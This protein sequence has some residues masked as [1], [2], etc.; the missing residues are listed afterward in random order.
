MN[1]IKDDIRAIR[2]DGEDLKLYLAR[3]TA[4][5]MDIQR[6]TS[7]IGDLRAEFTSEAD[8]N[9]KVEKRQRKNEIMEWISNHDYSEEQHQNISQFVEGTGVRG[10]LS[11]PKYLEWEK[12]TCDSLLCVGMPGAGKTVTSAMVIR[13]LNDSSR[14]PDV[15]V[16]V[17]FLYLR[18]DQQHTQSSADQLLCSLTRQLVNQA[19]TIPENIDKAFRNELEPGWSRADL[20]LDAV[21]SFDHVYFVVDALDESAEFK[22]VKDLFS[23]IRPDN[24]R[25]LLKPS[26]RTRVQL[27]VTSRYNLRILDELFKK[28]PP[29]QVEIKGSD[30]DIQHYATSRLSDLPSCV[31]QSA[32]LQQEIVQAIIASTKGVFLHAKLNMDSLKYMRRVK[33][34]KTA[35]K[36]FTSG[37][38]SSYDTSYDEAMSRITA[39]SEDDYRLAQTVLT[40]LVHTIRPLSEVELEA[41]LAVEPGERTLDP[42]NVIPITELQSLCAGL[43][44]V[45]EQARTVRLVHYTTKEYFLRN[46]QKLLVN[47][48]RALADICVSFLEFEEFNSWDSANYQQN[49]LRLTSRIKHYK[50]LT[51]AIVHYEDH[52]SATLPSDD[53]KGLELD[54]RLLRDQKRMD[55]FLAPRMRTHGEGRRMKLLYERK[56]GIQYAAGNGS[57]AQVSALLGDGI[58]KNDTSFGTTP[59]IEACASLNEPVVRLLIDAGADVNLRSTNRNGVPPLMVALGLHKPK[60]YETGATE[61]SEVSRAY[62]YKVNNPLGPSKKHARES[63]VAHLLAAGVDPNYTAEFDSQRTETALMFTARS[64]MQDLVAT[65]CRGGADVNRRDSMTGKTALHVAAE[66]GHEAIVAQLLETGCDPDI[67]DNSNLTP[68]L[69]ATAK[70]HWA[71]VGLLLDTAKVDVNRRTPDNAT[72]LTTVCGNGSWKAESIMRRLLDSN[73]A[74]VNVKGMHNRTPLMCAAAAVRPVALTR[75]ASTPGALRQAHAALRH[76]H[77]ALRQAALRQAATI[78]EAT[79]PGAMIVAAIEARA[80]RPAVVKMIMEAGADVHLADEDDNTVLHIVAGLDVSFESEVIDMMKLL[81]QGGMNIDI[82]GRNGAT[83]LMVATEAGDMGLQRLSLLL[84][85]GANVLL[86]DSKGHTA[87]AYAAGAGHRRLV[88]TLLRAC[89]VDK[90]DLAIIIAAG[91]GHVQILQLL[92]SAGVDVDTAA[93]NGTTAL[94]SAIENGHFEVVKILVESGVEVNAQMRDGTSPLM[95]AAIR[96]SR[97]MTRLLLDSGALANLSTV[98]GETALTCA[99]GYWVPRTTSP[100]EAHGC[101]RMLLEAGAGVDAS[102]EDGG[103]PLLLTSK[104]A[105]MDSAMLEVLVKAGADPNQRDRRGVTALMHVA[106]SCQASKLK[107]LLEGGADPNAISNNGESA[108]ILA[109]KSF[110]GLR[111]AKELLNAGANPNQEDGD[112]KTPLIHFISGAQYLTLDGLD[113]VAEA[114]V[115]AASKA[116]TLSKDD[117]LVMRAARFSSMSNNVS[118]KLLLAS[119]ANPRGSDKDGRNAIMLAA[120]LSGDQG[121]QAVRMLLDA[122]VDPHER[123]QNGDNALMLAARSAY[124]FSTFQ[125]LLDAGVDAHARDVNGMT[126]LMV[127]A[128]N[129]T[130]SGDRVRA[131]VEAGVSIDAVDEAGNTAL[132]HAAG[133]GCSVEGLLGAGADPNHANKQGETALMKSFPRAI[134]LAQKVRSLLDAGANVNVIDSHGRNALMWATSK[135]GSRILS[136]NKAVKMILSA[137]VA[138]DHMDGDGNTALVYSERVGNTQAADMIRARLAISKKRRRQLEDSC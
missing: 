73:P 33:A 16:A 13:R 67:A 134:N 55:F 14:R 92:I 128:S 79:K 15:M 82:R 108:L 48:H 102:T 71:I 9:R 68:V 32:E 11:D 57:C 104:N 123:D 30:L 27:L 111:V 113:E 46:P 10:L 47:P 124:N 132:I 5:S 65:F 110:G 88:T 45:D 127:V 63:I 51:Y 80:T 44:T 105:E 41:V 24:L 112:G 87:L 1:N 131:L 109:I 72:I 138:L 91:R 40:W 77:A 54:L 133:N 39:Q 122:G 107:V 81:H 60:M 50:F 12:G 136:H 121:H 103:T 76:A 43:I 34:I 17:A 35:L 74:G 6:D 52:V 29:V 115:T 56:T 93:G 70:S 7:Q 8:T 84:E 23:T 114:L 28:C 3:Q 117:T 129:S 86:K 118:L 126:T 90:H 22:I 18:Y 42:D 19:K 119:G 137:G 120:M 98:K 53:D 58:D 20:L 78:A 64:G 101:L 4:M 85:M 26:C 130:E 36:N 25:V 59:L 2:A 99:L 89:T 95:L 21:K 83:A 116:G 31:G 69:C 96:K 135:A 106:L 100:E 94:M 62:S 125:T 38:A 66:Y 97:E 37:S 75:A 61:H 49:Y